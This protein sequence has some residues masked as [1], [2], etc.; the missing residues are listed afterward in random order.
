MLLDPKHNIQPSKNFG[1]AVDDTDIAITD[2]ERLKMRLAHAGTSIS[3]CKHNEDCPV[4]D[5]C[6]EYNNLYLRP[7]C[8]NCPSR[9]GKSESDILLG[10]FWGILR[11][12]PEFYNPQGVSLVL[13][14]TEKGEQLFNSLDCKRM[15][16]SYDDALDCNINIEK[17]EPQPKNRAS[18]FEAYSKKG[19]YAIDKYCKQ[20]EVSGLK[21]FKAIV[22]I[23]IRKVVNNC[24]H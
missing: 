18:F 17:D 6:E 21:R 12:H 23:V 7:S 8:H 20:L 16:A 4:T 14:Y 3:R 10:D 9:H 5:I 1:Y 15:E 11:R 13:T 2:Y 19:V 22:K 24:K